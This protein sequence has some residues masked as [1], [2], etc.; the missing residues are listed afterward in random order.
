MA[1][2]CLVLLLCFIRG[3]CT[4]YK[5]F[6]NQLDDG[7][8]IIDNISRCI[9][10]SRRPFFKAATAGNLSDMTKTLAWREPC[11]RLFI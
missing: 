8:K 3:R 9:K 2:I 6:K 11:L 5:L 4:I 7:N 1:V 10:N